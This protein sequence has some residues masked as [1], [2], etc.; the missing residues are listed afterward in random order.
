M[1]NW[2]KSVLLSRKDSPFPLTFQL[3]QESCTLGPEWDA[4]QL[5]QDPW[6]AGLTSA[7]QDGLTD[8]VD[9]EVHF[10]NSGLY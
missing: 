5:N 1:A 10:K 9:G 2:H 3:Q 8:T 4:L 7:F 6:E